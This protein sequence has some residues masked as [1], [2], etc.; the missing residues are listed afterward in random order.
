M[1]VLPAN[2]IK[3]VGQKLARFIEHASFSSAVAE[4]FERCQTSFDTVGV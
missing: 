4:H 1:S 3:T 2:L